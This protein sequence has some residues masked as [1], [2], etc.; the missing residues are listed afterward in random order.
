MRYTRVKRIEDMNILKRNKKLL[1]D[2]AEDSLLSIEK[3]SMRGNLV[4][5]SGL[6]EYSYPHDFYEYKDIESCEGVR[7][8]ANMEERLKEEAKANNNPLEKN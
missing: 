8:T 5:Y 7:V 2:I 1:E 3:L 6:L 4:H